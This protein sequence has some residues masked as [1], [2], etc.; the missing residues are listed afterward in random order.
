MG[1]LRRSW[2]DGSP[3]LDDLLSL[4]DRS[5]LFPAVGSAPSPAD[6]PFSDC[7]LRV[8][9]QTV[10]AA[11]QSARIQQEHVNEPQYSSPPV[12]NT[13]M[14]SPLGLQRPLDRSLVEKIL[15]GDS[16]HAQGYCPI[17]DPA[18]RSPRGPSS[19]HCFNFNKPSGCSRIAC[20]FSSRV[21]PL[22]LSSPPCHAFPHR[23]LRGRS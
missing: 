2:K 14:A 4:Q 10:P 9:Q 19:S 16:Y 11:M 23:S 21:Q 12:R 20:H 18:R 8:L 22:P 3:S 6:T 17:A 7:Q 5:A 15:W 1:I 13:G